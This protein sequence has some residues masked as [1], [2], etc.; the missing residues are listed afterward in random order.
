MGFK[1]PPSYEHPSKRKR[2]LRAQKRTSED[3]AR[4]DR[5]LEGKASKCAVSVKPTKSPRNAASGKSEAQAETVLLRLAAHPPSKGQFKLYDD[6]RKS[7]LSDKDAILALL[8]KGTSKLRDIAELS[9][10]A[11]DA[12]SYDADALVIETNRKIPSELLEKLK[13]NI[14]PYDALTK[15]ALAL[16]LGQ[17]ILVLTIKEKSNE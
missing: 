9:M 10:S 1:Q 6:M 11:L 17:A 14:D 16:K 7:G 8:R 5:P 15:R 12:M 13:Q 4:T 2:G 3:V